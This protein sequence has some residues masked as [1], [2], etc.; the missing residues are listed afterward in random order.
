MIKKR[1]NCE[2]RREQTQKNKE[3]ERERDG[4]ERD[5]ERERYALDSFEALV[6]VS[7]PTGNFKNFQNS[8]RILEHLLWGD[9]AYFWGN[10]AQ[11][12][13]ISRILGFG[14]FFFFAGGGG[15]VWDSVCLGA[16]TQ[17]TLPS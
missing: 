9:N 7:P 14:D 13:G 12:R 10:K 16:R 1:E 5:R 15:G 11:S 4:G 3:R 6:A 17:R 8:L 2:R